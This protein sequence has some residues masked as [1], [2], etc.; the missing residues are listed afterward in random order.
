MDTSLSPL[1]PH[2]HPPTLPAAVI[3]PTVSYLAQIDPELPSESVVLSDAARSPSEIPQLPSLRVSG[4]ASSQCLAQVLGTANRVNSTFERYWQGD[5][6]CRR[7][8]SEFLTFHLSHPLAQECGPFYRSF[9]EPSIYT[10]S[11]ATSSDPD[12]IAHEQGHAILD[13]YG[14][15]NT[16]NSFTASA[17]E[18]FADVTAL[19]TSLQSPAVRERVSQSW[20]KGQLS[21][22]A[23]VIGEGSLELLHSHPAIS[24]GLRDLASPPPLSPESSEEEA[25]AASQRFSHGFYRAMHAI[26]ERERQRL[27]PS[28][29]LERTVQRCSGDFVNLLRYL[30]NRPIIEQADLVAALLQANEELNRGEELELYRHH[31]ALS[32]ST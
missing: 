28:E 16:M 22:L 10:S 11:E 20:E 27:P 7:P 4:E 23:S 29:S 8:G 13:G 12:I 19:I 9:P 32:S 31:L 5:Q 26:Y 30:P 18:A 6:I 21:T 24:G 15:Y 1:I 17:H 14:H 2:L 25:H 3:P